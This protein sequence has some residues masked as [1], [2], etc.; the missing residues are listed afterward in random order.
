M[1]RSN[2]VI[3]A[4]V[5]A[6]AN[7]VV[8]VGGAWKPSFSSAFPWPSVLEASFLFVLHEIVAVWP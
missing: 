1:W 2:A 5:V 6:L 3:A 8:G 7:V 4:H